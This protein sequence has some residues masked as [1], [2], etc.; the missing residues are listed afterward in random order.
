MTKIVRKIMNIYYLCFNYKK[1][2]KTQFLSQSELQEIQ[3]TKLKYI[4]KNAIENVPYYRNLN[5]K[6]DFD[7]FTLNELKKFPIINKAIVRENFDLFINNKV[8]KKNIEWKQT[9]GSSGKPF[10]VAKSY[11]SDAIEGIMGYRAWSMGNNRY[12]PRSPVILL[13]SLSPKENEPIYKIDRFRNYWYLSPYHINEYYLEIYLKIIN[14]SKAK[15]LKGYPSS[16]YIFT[17]LLKEKNIKIEQIKTIVTSSENLLPHYRKVIEE[18]WGVPVL[19]WYGQNERTVT[20]QQCEYG[21]YHNNDEYGYFYLDK[22]NQIIATSLINDTMPLINY[23]TGDIAI[24]C[25]SLKKKCQCGR[26]LAIKM[27][28]IDGRSDDILI[29]DDGTKIPTVNFYTAMERFA[30]IK[31][32]QIIQNENKSIDIFIEKFSDIDDNYVHEIADEIKERVGIL[33]ITIKIVN[34][35]VRDKKTE[36]IK[37]I[38]S[39]LKEGK[40]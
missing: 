34:T 9:S 39:K 36:K 21:S 22:N 23:A 1:F 11:F 38:I 30:K 27:K 13:R 12:Y 37:T 20:I 2:L 25:D 16:I 31:Q 14:S 33:P 15:V 5:I 10:K 24:P 26:G 17:L 29:K 28:G 40:V 35:I 6:V 19:D 4:L 18:Y 3:L 32:F 8:N 7:C